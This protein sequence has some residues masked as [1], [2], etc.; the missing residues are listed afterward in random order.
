MCTN[1]MVKIFK[2]KWVLVPTYFLYHR[3]FIYHC[4]NVLRNVPI[5]WPLIVHLKCPVLQCSTYLICR[6]CNVNF[7]SLFFTA[8]KHFFFFQ[9]QSL[10]INNQSEKPIIYYI[11]I[12]NDQCTSYYFLLTR[13][14]AIVAGEWT[15]RDFGTIYRMTGIGRAGP[16]WRW[17]RITYCSQ[18]SCTADL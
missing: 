8:K 17:A 15:W 18:T 11:N 3:F 9:K 14:S 2:K 1:K 10:K 12:I 16:E 4:W 5:T 6:R 7:F 13:L